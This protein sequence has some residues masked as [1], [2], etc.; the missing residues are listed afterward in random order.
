M[1]HLRDIFSSAEKKIIFICFVSLVF[2]LLMLSFDFYKEKGLVFPQ[3]LGVY[4]EVYLGELRTLNPLFTSPNSAEDDISSFVFSSL[5]KR[6]KKTGDFT[7]DLAK[8]WALG[9]E[10]KVFTFVLRD[11]VV[12]HDGVSFSSEDVLFTIWLLKNSD[13]KTKYGDIFKDVFVE[14]I[15]KNE[16]KFI[17]KEADIFFIENFDFPILPKHLLGKLKQEDFLSSGFNL[18]PIGTGIY[19]LR[20][21]ERM[22]DYSIISLE[23]NTNYYLEKPIIEKLVFQVVRDKELYNKYL[24]KFSGFL[25]EKDYHLGTGDYTKYKFPSSN[26]MLL[27]FNTDSS[28]LAD[29]EVRKTISQ[30]LNFENLN[31]GGIINKPFLFSDRKEDTDIEKLEE[32]VIKETFYSEGWQLYN[33]EF[34]DGLRRNVRKQKFSLKLITLD[35]D[36]FLKIAENIKQNLAKF[37]VEILYAGFSADELSYDFLKDK[38]YDLLLLG[39]NIGNVKD[40]FPYLHSSQ[41]RKADGLNFSLYDNLEMDL[42]LEDLRMSLESKRQEKVINE[43]KKRLTNEI[44]FIFVLQ[45]Y[46]DYYINSNITN[47]ELPQITHNNKDRFL[48]FPDWSFVK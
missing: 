48:T 4:S 10:G 24:D 42:L 22:E 32:Q 29:R 45:D 14:K 37:G 11:N 1:W 13:F 41:I 8:S 43:I 28:F 35:D 44:P 6:D 25:P 17:L 26:H 16:I 9:K 46:L 20:S 34:T 18:N 5:I 36:K 47:I 30:T 39:L 19:K 3:D 7:S 27:F 21:F 31:L 12:W 2:S 40:L 23:S 15:S 33:K 38:D